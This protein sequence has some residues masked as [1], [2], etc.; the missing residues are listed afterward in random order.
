MV[1]YRLLHADKGNRTHISYGIQQFTYK[2]TKSQMHKTETFIFKMIG[3]NLYDLAL[4]DG[5]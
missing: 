5:F 4:S 2:G 3:I 1:F